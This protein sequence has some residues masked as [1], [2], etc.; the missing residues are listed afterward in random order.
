MCEEVPPEA[1]E[2]MR[3]RIALIE[4]GDESAWAQEQASK[5]LETTRALDTKGASPHPQ[6]SRHH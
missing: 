3:A 4:A 1:M 5:S 6:Q 2:E